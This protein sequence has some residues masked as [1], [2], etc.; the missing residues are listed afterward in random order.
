GLGHD[1]Q[2]LSHKPRIQASPY[3]D[4]DDGPKMEGGQDMLLQ[5]V[6]F[7]LKIEIS[8]FGKGQLVAEQVDIQPLFGMSSHL[9]LDYVPIKSAG[10]LD[11]LTRQGKVE[12]YLHMIF[13]F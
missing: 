10:R 3:I 1:L 8:R 2:V 7:E 6:V 4:G 12:F 5:T 9:G 13:L 11:V